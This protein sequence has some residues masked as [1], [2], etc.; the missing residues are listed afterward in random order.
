MFVENVVQPVGRGPTKD[1]A[2]RLVRRQHHVKHQ[3][4]RHKRASLVLA[5]Q[6]QGQGEKPGPAQRPGT[7]FWLFPFVIVVRPLAASIAPALL[8]LPGEHTLLTGSACSRLLSRSL[9]LLT[10]FMSA[11]AFSLEPPLP[12]GVSV[13]V[14]VYNSEQTLRPLVERIC[15]VLA[16]RGPDFEIILVNDASR[17]QSWQVVEALCRD[18]PRLQGVD[19]LR[20]YGQHNALLCGVR[21]A[22][23][24][25]IV[26][27]DDDLQHPPEEIP[28]LLDRLAEGHDVVYGAPDK[29]PHGLWRN[30]ASQLTKMALRT[31]M[32][33]ETSRH[34]SAFRA[35]RTELR[36]A[37]AAYNSPHV[38]LDVLLTWGS[39]RFSH[40]LVRHEPRQAGVSNYTFRK[41]LAHAFT[42]ITGF[43]TWPL[44]LASWLGF[45]LT[46]F[47]VIILGVV[48]GRYLIEGSNVP[49]FPFL[50]SLIAI[51]SGAQL[52]ALGMIGEYLARIHFR[53]MDR[54]C[55]TIRRHLVPIPGPPNNASPP[56][57]GGDH[58][59]PHR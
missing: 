3:R 48:I 17:D 47:G 42:M 44:Q 41:L 15:A 4:G 34:V 1:Q 33:A 45:L 7:P 52:F 9:V 46:V 25:L 24:N 27:L 28:R 18:N 30:L 10:T 5:S 56:F 16:Q 43:S 38:S 2:A 11:L 59:V 53:L 8:P 49:G 31:V 55:F 12:P 50:A 29:L 26:T 57:C 21:L 20:N 37:F 54:P 19:L 39:S 22:R 14:P 13:V 40:V 51:F 32:G 23:F 36:R 6:Q 58:G 35:F